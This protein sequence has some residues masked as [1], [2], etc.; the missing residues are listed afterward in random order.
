MIVFCTRY[1]LRA[2]KISFLAHVLGYGRGKNHATPPP[3]PRNKTLYFLSYGRGKTFLHTSSVT[4]R[5]TQRARFVFLRNLVH[6]L[7]L[8]EQRLI[9][10]TPASLR[11]D[12]EP[13]ARNLLVERVGIVQVFVTLGIYRITLTGGCAVAQEGGGMRGGAG[14][15]D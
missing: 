12:L 7:V 10:E 2:G 14:G 4:G 13:Q 11:R 1:R 5:E 15:G 9:A 6:R 8:W 3:R